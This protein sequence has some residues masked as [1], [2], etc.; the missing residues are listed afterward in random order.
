MERALEL[1]AIVDGL[2]NATLN[3]GAK[4]AARSRFESAPSSAS[5]ASF[6]SA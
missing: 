6:F 4:A 5:S 1:T 2:E 3:S